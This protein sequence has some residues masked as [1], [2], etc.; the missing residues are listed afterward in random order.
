M[1]IVI[2]NIAAFA[3]MWFVHI[4]ISFWTTAEVYDKD[5]WAT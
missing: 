2:K 1:F 3:T 4:F 5:K